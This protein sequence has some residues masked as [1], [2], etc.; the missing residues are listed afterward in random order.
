MA[1]IDIQRQHSHGKP[2]AK[3]AVE[4]VA[5]AIAKEY[6]VDHRW[7]GDELHFT[8]HGVNGRIDVAEDRV[9]VHLELGFLMAAFKPVIEREIERQL[10]KYIA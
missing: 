9:H 4:R 3:V 10:D 6:G 1:T 8:R 7:N 5:E 2:M